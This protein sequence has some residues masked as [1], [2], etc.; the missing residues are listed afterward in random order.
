MPLV[1]ESHSPPRGRSVLVAVLTVLAIAGVV[2]FAIVRRGGTS[3]EDAIRAWFQSPAGGGAP[4]D[5]ARSIHVGGCLMTG[6]VSKSQDVLRCPITTDAPTPSLGTCFVIVDGKAIRGG[7]QLAGVDSCNALRYDPRTHDLV[8][9]SGRAH[10][11]L[12]ES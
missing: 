6:A 9:F 1:D 10:Y 7:W 12:T 3:D 2:V 11:P 8:D 4:A 5:L